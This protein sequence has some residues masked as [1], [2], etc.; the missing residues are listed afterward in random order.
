MQLITNRSQSAHL[1]LVAKPPRATTR[2]FLS[3]LFPQVSS[4]LETARY[5]QYW[6][7]ERTWT[8][9]SSAPGLSPASKSVSI[10]LIQI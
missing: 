1:V 5:L 4:L 7:E 2:E 3:H 9:T 6:D 8:P 10:V